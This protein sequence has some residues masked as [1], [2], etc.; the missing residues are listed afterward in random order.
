MIKPLRRE[1]VHIVYH[2]VALYQTTLRLTYVGLIMFS[3]TFLYFQDEVMLFSLIIAI[4][5]VFK[6][7]VIVYPM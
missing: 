2:T 3:K 5:F 4:H 7:S 6:H 1:T